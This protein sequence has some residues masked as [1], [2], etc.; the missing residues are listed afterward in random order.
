MAKKKTKT[1]SGL[2]TETIAASAEDSKA[3]SDA[4]NALTED[5]VTSINEREITQKHPGGR[6]SKF[7]TLDM[8]QTKKLY[9]AGWTD[10][11]VAEFYEVSE[12]TVTAWKKKD[13]KFLASIKDW[14]IEADE[15]VER[16]LYE[17]ACG[18]EY[19]E[20]TMEKVKPGGLGIEIKEG[21]VEQIK[22][23]ECHK[24]KVVTKKVVQD[25]TSM[26]FWL[27]NR[28]PKRWRDKHEIEHSG[29]LTVYTK[30]E[31]KQRADRLAEYYA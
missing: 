2:K 16:S 5:N 18:F 20:V 1:K 7:D 25:A 31:K 9:L 24:I 14:K 26:I 23:M 30:E 29:S 27:K 3:L 12:Q 28:L 15:K 6:P 17:R 22:H 13:P 11:Q 10:K 19:D 21:E 4:V 8:E